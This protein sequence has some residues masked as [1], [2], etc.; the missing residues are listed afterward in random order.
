MTAKSCL[1]FSCIDQA[2]PSQTNYNLVWSL[3]NGDSPGSSHF[4]VRLI[5]LNSICFSSHI[6]QQEVCW[7][8]IVTGFTIPIT[9]LVQ[10]S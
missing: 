10:I 9:P 6:L 7:K 1:Q 3:R 8:T 4:T 2:Y 5:F